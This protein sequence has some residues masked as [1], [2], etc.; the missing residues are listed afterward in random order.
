MENKEEKKLTW[1]QYQMANRYLYLMILFVL[2]GI[3]TPLIWG[4]DYILVLPAC[5]VIAILIFFLAHKAYKIYD[6]GGTS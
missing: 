4:Y 1:L 3:L 2:A 5:L 6:K